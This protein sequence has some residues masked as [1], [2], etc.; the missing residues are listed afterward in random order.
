MKSH[1]FDEYCVF[2]VLM[3]TSDLARTSDVQRH[4]TGMVRF[5]NNLKEEKM[6]MMMI[7]MVVMM[8]MMMIVMMVMMIMMMKMEMEMMTELNL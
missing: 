6:K 8:I 1:V 2:D 5:T 7:V 3:C 4:S